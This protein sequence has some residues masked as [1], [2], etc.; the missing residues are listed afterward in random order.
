MT[1]LDG[2][3]SFNIPTT[4]LLV[5]QSHTQT[6]LSVQRSVCSSSSS[7]RSDSG[8]STSSNCHR[9][10]ALAVQ[11]LG[12]NNRPPA[13]LVCVRG[14]LRR[15]HF[16]WQLLIALLV[17]LPLSLRLLELL[18]HTSERCTDRPVYVCVLKPQQVFSTRAH[19]QPR[20]LA[21]PPVW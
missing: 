19:L 20:A 1:P 12:G 4:L 10:W 2:T 18:L 6:G 21:T 14:V 15:A 17:L 13:R 8:N 5:G 11:T 7:S 16:L 3:W 9:K